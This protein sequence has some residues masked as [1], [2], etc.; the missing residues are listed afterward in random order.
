MCEVGALEQPEH[1]G[2]VIREQQVVVAEV[3]DDATGCLAERLVP[4]CFAVTLALRVVEEPDTRIVE[5]W[6]YGI[7]RVVLDAVADDKHLNGHA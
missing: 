6:Q 5:K 7:P 1:L 3:T 4:V 2:D